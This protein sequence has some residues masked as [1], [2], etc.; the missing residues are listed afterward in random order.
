M[1]KSQIEVKLMNNQLQI[2]TEVKDASKILLV[3]NNDSSKNKE[4][5][6]TDYKVLDE[7]IQVF[8]KLINVK[9]TKDGIIFW[10]VGQEEKDGQSLFLCEKLNIFVKIIAKC[11]DSTPETRASGSPDYEVAGQIPFPKF[12]TKKIDDEQITNSSSNRYLIIDASANHNKKINNSLYKVKD[13]EAFG[14]TDN[15]NDNF[16]KAKALPVN[17]SLTIFVKNYNFHD[18]ER[19]SIEIP[20]A[21]YNYT[22][23]F[24]DMFGQVKPIITGGGKTTEPAE[25]GGLE[26]TSLIQASLKNSLI[27]VLKILKEEP[28]YKFL[29]LN[30][31]YVIEKY[32]KELLDFYEKKFKDFSAADIQTLNEIIN[33]YPE[34]LSITPI[35]I[36]VPEND[37]VTINLKLKNKNETSSSDTKVGV[38]K[39]TGGIGFNLGGMF[40]ITNL[41]NNS[42]YTAPSETNGKVR[43][44]I[45]S[46]NQKSVGLGLNGEVYFRTGYLIRPTVNVGF[47]VPFDEDITPF[48]AVGPGVSIASKNLKFSFSW[49]LSVAKISTIK[50]Q[51]NGVE[52][53]ATGIANE[54]LSE[55]IWKLGNYFGFGLTYNLASGS[56][57]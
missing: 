6:L 8:E 43:A 29:N 44:Y 18:L 47:F 57:K 13:L 35:S 21:D 12:P 48:G 4:I 56:N 24:S 34:Y 2:N 25:D 11:N 3:H 32:K 30:D 39:S 42:V 45:D 53:D 52:F 15:F 41:K 55:K 1:I 16:K 19:I 10:V 37:E 23:S 27:N 51:Y 26:S 38:F 40:Y 7:K 20:G 50:K 14:Q 28:E 17:G 33:W 54:S 46:E 22:K 5:K 49:G 31:L 9:K 36:T